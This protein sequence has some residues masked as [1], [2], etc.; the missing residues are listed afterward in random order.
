VGIKKISLSL[1]ILA[2]LV[3]SSFAFFAVAQ[4][5]SATGNNIFLDSDQDGLTDEEERMYGTD[6][7]NKDTD[8]DGYSDGAEVKSGYDPRKPAPGD[9][10]IASD[11]QNSDNSPKNGPETVLG[12]TTQKN[13]ETLTQKVAQKLSELATQ[14]NP[15]DQSLSLEQVQSMID[16]SLDSE[17]S[18]IQIPE[19]KK[20]DFKIKKQNYGSLSDEKAKE[21]RKEDFLNYTTAVFY[22]LS[23]NS[24]KPLTSSANFVN[25]M[26]D[27]TQKIT[28]AFTSGDAS[29]LDDLNKSGE[30]IIQQLK[31]VEIPEEM[32]DTHI[33]VLQFAYYAKNLEKYI[34]SNASD[35]MGDIANLSK[36]EGFISALASFSDDIGKKFDEYGIKYDSVLQDKLKG[37]GIAPASAEDE[38]L[39]KLSE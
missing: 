32:A 14:V 22:I 15:D 17:N 26:S 28:S 31:E 30:K 23:S 10:I 29:S 21:K 2:S 9:R 16:E 3:F 34:Q 33:K 6:P 11:S 24:P 7:R 18:D 20:N 36:V 12:E 4:N 27:M 8:G 39:K 35:P 37:Y 1:L 13:G 5:N 19:I 38:L 25:I